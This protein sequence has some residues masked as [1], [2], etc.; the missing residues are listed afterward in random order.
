MWVKDSGVFSSWTSNNSKKNDENEWII[1]K[2]PIITYDITNIN[3]Q[4]TNFK[5]SNTNKFS[6]MIVALPI[7]QIGYNLKISQII[8]QLW[9][10]FLIKINKIVETTEVSSQ[11]IIMHEPQDRRSHETA[12]SESSTSCCTNPMSIFIM[13]SSS[14]KDNKIESASVHQWTL[15]TIEQHF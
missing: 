6:R 12:R 1:L 14:S 7:E 5:L 13:P 2:L 4:M 15:S 8:N 10:S 3:S 9:S 11:W